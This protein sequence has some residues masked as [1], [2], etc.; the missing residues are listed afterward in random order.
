[1]AAQIHDY[2]VLI[3]LKDRT[4]LKDFYAAVETVLADVHQGDLLRVILMAVRENPL[5]A[6]NPSQPWEYVQLSTNLKCGI[7]QAAGAPELGTFT[8]TFGADTTA[9]IAYNA[10][11]ATVQ[12]ALN[13]LASVIAAGNVTVTGEDGGPWRCVFGNVG[14][15]SPMTGNGDALYPTSGV[16]VLTVRNGTASLKE[17][18]TIALERQPAALCDF[19]DELPAAG[20]TVETLQQGATDTPDVQRITLDPV[21]Y[22]GTFTLDF[23]GEKTAAIAFDATAEELQEA[24]AELAGIGTTTID[25]EEVDNVLV[26]GASP[27]WVVTFRNTMASADQTEMT[28]DASGLLVP[29]GVVGELDLNTEGIL[30]LL[31]NEEEVDLTFEVED[32]SKPVTLLHKD[33]TVIND[34]IPDNPGAPVGIPTYLTED[35]TTQQF[36]PGQACSALTGGAAGALDALVT[37]D[38]LTVGTTF[39]VSIVSGVLN[40]W[41]LQTN[42]GGLTEDAANGRVLPD[43]ADALTNNVIWIK[44]L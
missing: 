37:D 40:I 6:Q 26:T 28:G 13:L 43:D 33:I 34:L 3:N 42:T 41:N 32:S 16:S 15:R 14:D 5:A 35:E 20:V 23:D 1:M 31:A 9:A 10:S 2:P 19:W 39:R 17:I 24:L 27:R 4:A 21:P 44:V 12:T 29:L 38:F 22:G 25:D 18:Q 36:L 7:G 30:D 8:I 11:A